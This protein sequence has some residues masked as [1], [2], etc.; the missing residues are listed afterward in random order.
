M[1]GDRAPFRGKLDA[2]IPANGNVPP[3]SN[4]LERGSPGRR[5]QAHLFAQ[6]RTDRR[7]LFLHGFPDRLQI[8][9]LGNAGLLSTHNPSI[10]RARERLRKHGSRSH[11]I[12]LPPGSRRRPASESTRASIS[13]QMREYVSISSP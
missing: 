9:F 4:A 1:L 10:R 8:I 7:L 2:A 12:Y 11:E 5:R 6:A 13:S 3:A